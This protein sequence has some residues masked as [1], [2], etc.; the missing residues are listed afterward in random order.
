M[1]QRALAQV[2]GAGL[3]G[4]AQHA[5]ARP[6][7]LQDLV[8]RVIDVRAVADQQ[9]GQHRHLE[10]VLLRDVRQ[11]AQILRQARAAEG[12]AGLQVRRRDVQA[13][14]GAHQPHD[15]V[16][17]DAERLR[18]AAD[19][20]GEGDLERVEGVAAHLERFGHADTGHEEAR[21]EVLE[22]L[23]HRVDR[24]FAVAADDGVR[25]MV[26]VADRTALAQELRLERQTEIHARL[27]C[28]C[29]RSRMG[30][31][32]SSSVPGCT[33]ERT[34]MVWKSRLVLSA[35]PICS[36]SRRMALRSWLP[37]AAD[38]V[39]TQTNDTSVS[40]MALRGIVA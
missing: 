5:D 16:R 38:G 10:I 11:R 33:V 29:S 25:R 1:H 26:V 32:F 24:G 21:V 30:S 7:E 20:V 36:A 31:I 22:D 8:H 13:R 27:A 28:R 39:P 35:A 18:D 2:V 19:L 40:C 12:E 15:L 9:A 34:T 37:F 4:Q 6:A 23:A 14:I 3:E 17:V